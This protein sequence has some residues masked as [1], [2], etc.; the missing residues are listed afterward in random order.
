M[1]Q[2]AATWARVRRHYTRSHASTEGMNPKGGYVQHVPLQTVY[3]SVRTWCP[4]HADAYQRH[5]HTPRSHAHP[6]NS[7]HPLRSLFHVLVSIRRA[8]HPHTQV[9][10]KTKFKLTRTGARKVPI[11]MRAKT[12]TCISAYVHRGRK[13][14]TCVFGATHTYT[15]V[16]AGSAIYAHWRGHA[17]VHVHRHTRVFPYSCTLMK[18][19]PKALPDIPRDLQ[20][21]HTFAHYTG[22]GFQ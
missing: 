21:R 19:M 2:G 22:Q 6:C 8:L 3:A 10:T 9:R 11:G 15:Y 17:H 4:R 14:V 20:D 12:H 7:G 16:H 5:G 13:T 18:A 1:S